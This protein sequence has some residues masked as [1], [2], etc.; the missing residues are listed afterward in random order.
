MYLT[1]D[2]TRNRDS[3]ASRTLSPIPEESEPPSKKR[4]QPNQY[5]KLAENTKNTFSPSVQVLLGQ[6]VKRK[7]PNQYTK[8]PLDPNHPHKPKERQRTKPKPS[9]VRK[10]RIVTFK[11]PPSR[12]REFVTAAEVETEEQKNGTDSQ[13]AIQI[14]PPS[15]HTAVTVVPPSPSGGVTS[16]IGGALNTSQAPV[17]SYDRLIGIVQLKRYSKACRGNSSLPPKI[18]TQ[19]EHIIEAR[20][21]HGWLQFQVQAKNL[22]RERWYDA[23]SFNMENVKGFKEAVERFYQERPNACKFQDLLKVQLEKKQRSVSNTPRNTPRNSPTSSPKPTPRPSTQTTSRPEVSNT[24]TLT[25]DHASLAPNM[26]AVAGT[27]NPSLSRLNPD[28]GLVHQSGGIQNMSSAYQNN[29]QVVNTV[30][31]NM[32]RAS[33]IPQH[34]GNASIHPSPY[35]SHQSQ[36]QSGNGPAVAGN[37]MN[38]NALPPNFQHPR[39]NTGPKSQSFNNHQISE[40]FQASSTLQVPRFPHTQ[41]PPP[42]AQASQPPRAHQ[43]PYIKPPFR[44]TQG[45]H[46]PQPHLNPQFYQ[47]TK[48]SQAPKSSQLPQITSLSGQPEQLSGDPRT[49]A[50]LHAKRASWQE[51]K[52]VDA[53]YQHLRYVRKLQDEQRS[54]NPQYIL[55][56][57]SFGSKHLSPVPHRKFLGSISQQKQNLPPHDGAIAQ[58]RGM[59]GFVNSLQNSKHDR[60]SSLKC[61][62]A[63]FK[64]LQS[65]LVEMQ[66]NHCRQNLICP[67]L[68]YPQCLI[69]KETF[70]H[71]RSWHSRRLILR[72][73][74]RSPITGHLH[75]LIH[76][77]T[78]RY[79]RTWHLQFS[80][81]RIPLK[82]SRR[83][84]LQC[85]I[86]EA[87]PMFP[88]AWHFH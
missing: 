72:I 54:Q 81:L 75:H 73:S 35:W 51:L 64:S 71:P 25:L 34:V 67:R 76:K 12:L 46:L 32:M 11:L 39:N 26:T 85:Y 6:P 87:V 56:S 23:L 48:A 79:P 53:I 2:G 50:V 41:L 10:Q 69:P 66:I 38:A 88:M 45:S 43:F 84:H 16:T 20:G 52:R 18:D 57:P 78:R 47:A 59:N 49:Q 28:Y 22:P 1:N 44:P 5:T 3:A 40:P 8:R 7:Q 65:N 15:T 9:R 70:K 21:S 13:P 55:Q 17:E 31:S 33:L 68:H 30:A 86:L 83:N 82:S 36:A 63:N 58:P 77:R 62:G 60:L 74:L 27:I 80:I 4:K 29:T 42:N 24:P 37:N 14:Q 61:T 19:V